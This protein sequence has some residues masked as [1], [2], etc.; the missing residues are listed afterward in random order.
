MHVGV[1]DE[2]KTFK[3]P[4]DKYL[5]DVRIVSKLV[6]TRFHA[7]WKPNLL[8]H[9]QVLLLRYSAWFCQS[10]NAFSGRGDKCLAHKMSSCQSI[11]SKSYEGPPSFNLTL[12][13]SQLAR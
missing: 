3:I 4:G 2:R 10:A 5:H 8:N 1:V 13:T 12:K 9:D 6:V 11:S 7:K